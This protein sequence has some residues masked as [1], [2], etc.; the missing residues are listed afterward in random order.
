MY[1]IDRLEMIR[2]EKQAMEEYGIPSVILMENAAMGFV[3]ALIKEYGDTKNK[4]ICVLCGKGNN[5]GDGY[6]I[7]RLLHFG[8]A[9]V[10]ILPVFD[11]NALTGDAKLNATV[12]KNMGIP[13]ITEI[14]GEYDIII[15]AIFGTGFHGKIESPAKEIIEKINRSNAYIASVDIP[16]GVELAGFAENGLCVMADLCVT[17][18]YAKYM[19]FVGRSQNTFKKM[20][21]APIS[22]P[23]PKKICHLITKNTFGLI[24]KRSA[25]S[26]KGTFGKVLAFVGSP[27]MA[28]AAILSGSAILKSGAGMA[29][30]ASSDVIIPTLAHEFPSVMTCPLPTENGDLKD[31]AA[32]LLIKK[33]TGMDAILLGCGLGK[34][35]NTKK[36]VSA[37]LEN[38]EIPMVIDADGLNILS[39]NIDIL[40]GKN[41]ILT[42]HIA[43]FSRLS[44]LSVDTIKAA[45]I[46]SV[47]DF[48]ARYGVTVVL[49]DAVTII[50]DRG[51]NIAICHAPNSG[52]ATAGSGDVLA[53]VIT[54]LLAQG[55]SPF[56][57]ACAG[58]YVHSAAGAIAREELGEA[59]M[60]STDIL[61]SVPKA[62]M[63][64]YDIAPHIK[65]L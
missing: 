4:K 60:T 44:G 10:Y 54:S 23:E 20:I 48:T 58:V 7:A 17:F 39:E 51:E 55:V 36:T 26:H 6:A 24:P 40:H 56:D 62:F 30:V 64:P 2:L 29:T 19:Q 18:G 21:V 13:F 27:G 15:D 45:P 5:G 11:A 3:S 16:S 34:S 65:E 63:A 35:E 47:T 1:A 22:V 12:A 52:M 41:L 42:P 46:E 49:K 14:S 32:D 61:N 25:I 57:A 37:L 8:G 9:C 53:G 28:G 31:T 59:G 38:C 43:E 33:T 50:C